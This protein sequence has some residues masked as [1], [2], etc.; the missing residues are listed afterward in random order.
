MPASTPT[1]VAP[2]RMVARVT[3]EWSSINLFFEFADRLHVGALPTK[4]LHKLDG[5]ANLA[6]RV[7][8][9]DLQVFNGHWACIGVLVEQRF[10]HLPRH[11]FVLVKVVALLDVV[12][13][14]LARQRRLV[15][16]NVADEVEGV[17]S[18]I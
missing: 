13:T 17:E 12:R 9:Q 3:H 8:L 1:T 10:Q 5:R 4:G 7:Q 11:A 2:R 6:E 18:L 14:F 16:G 15:E